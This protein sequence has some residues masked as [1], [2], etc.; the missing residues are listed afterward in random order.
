MFVYINALRSTKNNSESLI[1]MKIK[2]EKKKEKLT[3]N[4]SQELIERKSASEQRASEMVNHM[5]VIIFWLRIIHCVSLLST[6]LTWSILKLR[7][8]E[9]ARVLEVGALHRFVCV[10]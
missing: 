10:F 2:E 9:R 8:E 6:A 3:Q 1:E 4:V 7:F 5:P